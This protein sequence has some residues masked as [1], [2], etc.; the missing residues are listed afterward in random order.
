M[1]KLNIL[2][3]LLIASKLIFGQLNWDINPADYQF[4]HNITGK[5]VVDWDV[6]LEG[7]YTLGAFVDDECRG[8]ATCNYLNE[9]IIFLTMYSNQSI[10]EEISF[11]FKNESSEEFSLANVV[12]FKSDAITCNPDE[13]FEWMEVLDYAST[14]FLS[15]AIS[16]CDSTADINPQNHTIS[17]TIPY[18]M[19]LTNLT[20]IFELAPGAIAEIN[21]IEQESEVDSHDFTEEL[22]YTV[23]GV[24]ASQT[25]WTVEI[26]LGDNSVEKINN[27]D[28]KIFPTI[29][30]KDFVNIDSEK[31]L[32]YTIFSIKGKKLYSGK[33]SKGKNTLSVTGTGIMLINLY[34]ENYFV[35]SKRIVVY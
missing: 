19:G 1:K 22:V 27:L 18:E 5:I 16:G 31:E 32:S 34:Q 10:G 28:V 23:T 14:D 13:P 9:D 4:T 8:T 2:I 24:D 33:I 3:T 15:Y 12:Q 21:S 30:T 17:M 20:P 25:Q 26:T 35:T 29:I 11:T 7:N 6:N